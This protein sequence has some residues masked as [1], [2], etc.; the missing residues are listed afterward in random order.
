M[1]RWKSSPELRGMVMVRSMSSSPSSRAEARLSS[2]SPRQ[3]V[4]SRSVKNRDSD[5]ASG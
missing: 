2:R 5:A 1:K 4:A 3:N